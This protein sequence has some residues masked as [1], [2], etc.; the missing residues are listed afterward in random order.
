MTNHTILFDINAEQQLVPCFIKAEDAA[1]A[2]T[3]SHGFAS[4]DQAIGF[5]SGFGLAERVNQAG[6]LAVA[7]DRIAA[8]DAKQDQDQKAPAEEAA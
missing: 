7:L 4:I 2:I 1:G 8:S 6:G 5:L 3:T